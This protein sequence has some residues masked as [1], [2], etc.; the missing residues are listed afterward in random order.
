MQSRSPCKS[1]NF[2]EQ[3]TFFFTSAFFASPLPIFLKKLSFIIA[4]ISFCFRMFLVTQYCL[5]QYFFHSKSFLFMSSC[6][7]VRDINVPFKEPIAPSS[8]LA[9][10]ETPGCR[11]FCNINTC[12]FRFDKMFGIDSC[13]VK[14][15]SFTCLQTREAHQFSLKFWSISAICVLQILKEIGCVWKQC[16]AVTGR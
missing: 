5:T 6:V 14:E 12:C 9:E 2:R 11:V 7:K 10:S 13:F 4:P 3:Q 16:N 15:F 1:G 8:S